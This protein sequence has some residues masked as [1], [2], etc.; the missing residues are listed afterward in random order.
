M[1]PRVDHTDPDPPAERISR[2]LSLLPAFGPLPRQPQR[3]RCLPR[4]SPFRPGIVP[5]SPCLWRYRGPSR[6]ESAK[7]RSEISAQA[8]KKDPSRHR[9]LHVSYPISLGPHSP[10]FYL[11]PYTLPP[12]SCYLLAACCSQLS[13]FLIQ[14]QTS[15]TLP[16]IP[17]LPLNT[18]HLTLSR[19]VLITLLFA[20]C[21]LLAASCLLPSAQGA[22][23]SAQSAHTL[24]SPPYLLT[25]RR[26]TTDDRRPRST[27]R[28]VK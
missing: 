22:R 12:A 1:R 21:F 5:V 16:P 4:Q 6:L 18:H 27:E 24:Y 7:D 15:Y 10:S 2:D 9:I 3:Y 25:D 14:S 13:V 23:R 20:C 19:S 17:F 11:T 8:K 26:P 28:P